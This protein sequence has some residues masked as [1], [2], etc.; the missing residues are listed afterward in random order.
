[1][2]MEK[3]V[4]RRPVNRTA[5]RVISIGPK[6]LESSKRIAQRHSDVP[7]PTRPYTKAYAQSGNLP[8]LQGHVF[9]AL[10]VIG[11]WKEKTEA[12]HLRWVCRCLCGSYL[13]RSTRSVQNH[14]N[15]KDACDKCRHL[16]HLKKAALWRATGINESVEN[17]ILIEEKCRKR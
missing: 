11:L 9:G 7:L 15:A 14:H 10:T 4:T 17:F 3:I 1:M 8:N 5:A 13:T 12:G 2:T 6:G 16:A